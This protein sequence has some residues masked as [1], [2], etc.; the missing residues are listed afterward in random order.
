MS[1][2]LDIIEKR[3]LEVLKENGFETRYQDF[4]QIESGQMLILKRPAALIDSRSGSNFRETTKQTNIMANITVTLV[5][6]NLYNK[7][8]RE[9]EISQLRDSLIRT[10][11]HNKL[12]L[13]VKNGLLFQ[14]YSN[15]TYRGGNSDLQTSG[16]HV[17]EIN[18][19]AEYPI[20]ELKQPEDIERGN[21]K[22]IVTKYFVDDD[23]L[24][25]METEINFNTIDGGTAYSGSQDTIQGGSSKEDQSKTI[26][27]GG[28][29]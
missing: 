28:N 4:Q 9:I 15:A 13:D 2:L 16:F 26:L 25:E 22:A 27:N 17:D 11:H 18:F 7:A 5:I 8:A 23:S 10:L 1:R 3:I 6:Q 14:S 24:E 21:L 19:I 12:G 20:I 29:S